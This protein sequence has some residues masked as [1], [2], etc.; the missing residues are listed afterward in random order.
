MRLVGPKHGPRCVGW[1]RTWQEISP[2]NK[3]MARDGL[4]K[5]LAR[6][7]ADRSVGRSVDR[8]HIAR[9][10]MMARDRLVKIMAG[11]WL[12]SQKHCL[13]NIMVGDE[14]SGH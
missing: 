14:I 8:K 6:D 11:D 10:E 2:S 3:K 13:V 7:E 4:V 12:V 5:Y 9:N 1:L